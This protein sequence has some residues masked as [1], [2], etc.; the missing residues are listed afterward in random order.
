M[1][2]LHDDIDEA[3]EFEITE[4]Q[5]L[6]RSY[7]LKLTGDPHYSEDILQKT[8]LVIWK[9]RMDWD[10]ETVF[11]KWAYRIAYFQVKSHFRDLGRERKRLL[12]DDSVLELLSQDEPRFSSSS[13][14]MEALDSCLGKIDAQKRKIILERY[15]GRLSVE[16]LAEQQGISANGLSQLL[17]RIR[18]KLADCISAQT[19]SATS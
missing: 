14:L 7:I 9:K 18:S 6:L 17:R 15:E 8:N 3:F 19:E 2:G 1:G 4:S 11:M 10:P 13:H 16:D 12:F 5:T